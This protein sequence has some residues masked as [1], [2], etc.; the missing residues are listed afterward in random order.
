M[1]AFI[2][3]CSTSYF[4]ALCTTARR[5][6][7]WLLPIPISTLAIR[8]S[9]YRFGAILN[10]WWRSHA[11]PET[12]QGLN[13]RVS[14]E[15]ISLCLLAPLLNR[16]T[17][18]IIQSPPSYF[19]ELAVAAQNALQPIAD[20]VAPLWSPLR[21]A[22]APYI[23][24]AGGY[25]QTAA[26][27]AAPH[28]GAANQALAALEPWQLVL[29][30]ALLTLAVAR[31]L[32]VAWRARRAW[33]DKGPAQL[34][35]AFLLDL[36][37]IRGLVAAQQEKLVS[38]I[39]AGLAAKE[40]AAA[41][42]PPLRALPREGVP[43]AEV[44]QRLRY[45]EQ[46][47]VRFQDGDSHVSGECAARAQGNRR[48]LSR[49]RG[50]AA[51]G[52]VGRG[53]CRAAACLA[54]ST[55]CDLPPP[56]PPSHPGTV[57]MAGAVHKQLLNEAYQ[58]FSL[59]NPMH[60]NVFPRHGGRRAAAGAGGSRGAASAVVQSLQGGLWSPSLSCGPCPPACLQCAAHGGRG[61]CHDRQHAGG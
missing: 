44:K 40:A 16:T 10:M 48:I 52:V 54:L 30:T 12:V 42:P 43:P 38:K 60:A 37:G 19:S 13:A 55:M 11:P 47:D 50:G 8:W 5:A 18:H 35:S 34:A 28:L 15:S 1:T 20:V 33:Q 36:P 31:L 32:A 46:E 3:R 41:G 58:M 23:S 45:K 39:R 57:Y 26:G 17:F 7:R 14:G 61:C 6:V 24:L 22:L 21:P 2:D 25:C 9:S 59:S 27:V 49:H 53:G 4:C 56:P 51:D 29:A